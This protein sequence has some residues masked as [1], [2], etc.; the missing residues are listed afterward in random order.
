MNFFSVVFPLNLE[1][2]IY[3]CREDIVSLIKPGMLVTA[4]VK[5]SFKKG[6]VTEIVNKQYSDDIKFIEQ[7]HGHEPV[8]SKN[9][10][11]LLKW[12]SEYY[13]TNQGIILKNILPGEF[14]ELSF[15][16]NENKPNMPDFEYSDNLPEL[17]INPIVNLFFKS[18]KKDAYQSY[19]LHVN[20]RNI[21]YSFIL[22]ITENFRN[23]II[24]CPEI[25][26][27][28]ILYPLFKKAFGER[29]C[30][31]HSGL[32]KTQKILSIE[33]IVSGKSDIVIGTRH[34]VFAPF[35]KVSLI[36]VLHEHSSFYKLD[37]IP[38]YNVRDVAVMRG[39]YE[40]SA[41][42][43]SS[44][45]P[46]IES[47]YNCLSRKYK[48]LKSDVKVKRP[49]IKIVDT[50][51]N[52]V[53]KPGISKTVIESALYSI[54]NGQKVMFVINKKGYASI[55]HCDDCG[56]IQ[57]CSNCG[58]PLTINKNTQTLKCRY[59]NYFL[60]PIPEQCGR[61]RGY[62]LRMLGTG[63][64]RIQEDL[65]SLT[66]LKTIRI[67]SD[68]ASGKKKLKNLLSSV[69]TEDI[70]LIIGTKLM[71]NRIISSNEFSKAIILN[72]DAFLN[73]PDF[74][75]SEKAYQEF[76]SIADKILPDGEI[77]VQTQI[78]HNYLY[79]Y[80]KRYD[81]ISFLKEE[82]KRRKELNYPP[83]SKIILIK[84][85]S[86]YNIS[87]NIENI[88]EKSNKKVQI[89]GP[90][91][92]TIGK[93]DNNFGM[94]LKSPDRKSLRE[95]ANLF[96]EAFKHDRKTKLWINVDPLYI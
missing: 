76:V 1:P 78:P 11:K 7:I 24:L 77:L 2:L 10:L 90:F 87:D 95:T 19:L 83:F 48:L 62:N 42:L 14:F 32:S 12:M 23:I 82:L 52:S 38:F 85:K 9:M 93:E 49:K 84:L 91:K 61:C 45:S 70:K 92:S 59:C 79:K 16:S 29:V 39:Y 94:L 96:F 36:A 80:L 15:S 21:E 63:T 35:K 30:Q 54:N 57:K 43:L 51:Y 72:A 3:K 60:S 71:T 66:G 18:L 64:Q 33:K 81:Y 6:I 74:R 86:K 26:I 73:F 55:M 8:F 17:D 40:K 41:V 89:S 20:S 88:I 47:I 56:Y 28:D 68:I 67:D 5:N 22:R 53:L 50:R 34:A 27:V 31:Y 13:M 4:P 25:S 37:K 65:E 46:S 44:I 58:I 75:A 69:S